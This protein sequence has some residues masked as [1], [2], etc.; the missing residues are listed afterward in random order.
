[1]SELEP[2]F[3]LIV[4]A[5]GLFFLTGIIVLMSSLISDDDSPSSPVATSSPD[6]TS[7]A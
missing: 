3:W 1:M 2:G 5:I 4:L 7:I 6:D